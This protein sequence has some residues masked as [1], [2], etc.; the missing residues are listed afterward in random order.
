MRVA[1]YEPEMMREWDDFVR[2]SKNGTFLFMRG[3]MDYHS[4]RF[5][6]QLKQAM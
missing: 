3:Y 5:R 1:R 2:G 6:D 4:D